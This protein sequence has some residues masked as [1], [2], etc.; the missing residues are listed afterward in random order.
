MTLTNVT[1]TAPVA[2]PPASTAAAPAGS[3]DKLAN[4]QTFLQLL[5]AQLQNQNPMNPA[6]GTQ[7]VTQLAQFSSLEQLM[8]IN[9]GIGTISSSLTSGSTGSGDPTPPAPTTPPTIAASGQ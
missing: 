2:A 6:D 1:A 9:K 3:I 4:E 8:S 7:F 5:V